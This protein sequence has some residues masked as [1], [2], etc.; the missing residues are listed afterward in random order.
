MQ[1][2]FDDDKTEDLAKY[3]VWI[4]SG[5]QDVLEE[6]DE[7]QEILPKIDQILP[8]DLEADS[9]DTVV[10]TDEV[11]NINIS[12]NI[13]KTVNDTTDAESEPLIEASYDDLFADEKEEVVDLD[14][15][16]EDFNDMDDLLPNI[17]LEQEIPIED[18]PDTNSSS[19]KS[20]KPLKNEEE[21]KN[22]SYNWIGEQTEDEEETS[23]EVFLEDEMPAITESIQETP[24]EFLDKE[25][26]NQAIETNKQD[27]NTEESQIQDE[28]KLEDLNIDN[29]TETLPDFSDFIDSSTTQEQQ[30][31]VN[32]QLSDIPDGEISMDDFFSSDSDNSTPTDFNEIS[33]DDFMSGSEGFVSE[34]DESVVFDQ[35]E[36]LKIDLEFDD[37]FLNEADKHKSTNVELNDASQ[38]FD[39]DFGVEIIDETP[40]DSKS[41]TDDFSVDSVEGFDF[42]S[43]P[44]ITEVTTDKTEDFVSPKEITDDFALTDNAITTDK[45]V[46]EKT[47]ISAI[48]DITDEFSSFSTPSPQ[49]ELSSTEIGEDV[50]SEFDDILAEVGPSVIQETKT[51]THKEDNIINITVSEEDEDFEEVD[52]GIDE[53][54]T[55]EEIKVPLNIE[56]DEIQVKEGKDSVL[57]NKAPSPEAFDISEVEGFECLDEKT[58]DVTDFFL[59]ETPKTITPSDIDEK[60]DVEPTLGEPKKTEETLEE[61]DMNI[62]D[63]FSI[64]ENKVFDETEK[65][66]DNFE[67]TEYND[68]INDPITKIK[69]EEKTTMDFDDIKAV[70]NDLNDKN[71]DSI[72]FDMQDLDLDN[73]SSENEETTNQTFDEKMPD[74]STEIEEPE[75]SLDFDDNNLV[76]NK[77]IENM[78]EF[79][80]TS[81][82]TNEP[83]ETDSSEKTQ[84]PDCEQQDISEKEEEP[85]SAEILKMIATELSSI[86]T[87]LSS[88][89]SE[90][91]TLKSGKNDSIPVENNLNET[92]TEE[93]EIN[94]PDQNEKASGF[95]GDDDTDESIALTGD[96]LNNILITADFTPEEESEESTEKEETQETFEESE[97][98]EDKEPANYSEISTQE[99]NE[100]DE[101]QENDEVDEILN[102]TSDLTDSVD[103]ILENDNSNN[104]LNSDLQDVE[105]VPIAKM[106]DNIDY[107]DKG[108]D[109][110]DLDNVA[111]DEQEIPSID[112]SNEVLEE[113]NVDNFDLNF[114]EENTNENSFEQEKTDATN[115][116]D[117]DEEIQ[118][119]EES[120]DESMDISNPFAFEEEEETPVDPFSTEEIPSV[121]DAMANL[122][123][124][125]GL[126]IQDTFQ[127]PEIEKSNE[128]ETTEG[129]ALTDSDIFDSLETSV[130]PPTDSVSE[131]II[132]PIND[133]S[134]EVSNDFANQIASNS[135]PDTSTQVQNTSDSVPENLKGDIKSVLS[136]MDQLLESLPEDK[137]E[138]FA[139]SEHFQVYKKLFDELGLS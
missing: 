97:N 42:D 34:N 90:L 115:S 120:K 124:D 1:S 75:I 104:V 21:E 7:K 94:I 134:D 72:N 27:F 130:T 87:E 110:S 78:N 113:P 25:S 35:E 14:N 103:S 37:E 16:T 11:K 85:K 128:N 63:P 135:E 10:S 2:A 84:L 112:F 38:F 127:V 52:T 116:F 54:S 41:S 59:D 133:M 33:L 20:D 131:E 89:K 122:N 15:K 45:I 32:S 123:L 82:E 24:K 4:K 40:A 3:G 137:I 12:D 129:D 68:I 57:A 39:S 96:E 56:K 18:S 31:D 48:E 93:T 77:E 79:E 43:I 139:K 101:T 58:G 111:I 65:K 121:E 62:S 92:L 73:I 66:S 138:E 83:Q 109:C 80:A 44:D 117:S 126:E 50:T 74:I 9:I 102:D 8:D 17:P 81:I 61:I 76:T 19:N 119:A 51:E 23:P 30:K 64:D 55:E 86:K 71:D 136:Y 118:L 107:L 53:E 29:T 13:T 99:N 36:P 132:E 106:P 46:D 60:L 5:P 69:D 49:E 26:N 125:E 98:I 28:I 108:L 114:A 6:V 47:Q 105:P 22:Y 70:E 91:T 67:G 88:L 95:F 100:I